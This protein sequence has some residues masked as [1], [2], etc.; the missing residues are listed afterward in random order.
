MFLAALRDKLQSLGEEYELDA[1]EVSRAIY[2][3]KPR[4]KSVSRIVLREKNNKILNHILSKTDETTGKRCKSLNLPPRRGPS[5]P[6]SKTNGSKAQTKRRRSASPSSSRK[7]MVESDRLILEAYEYFLGRLDELAPDKALKMLENFMTRIYVLVCIPSCTRIARSIVMGLGKGKNLEPVD[8]FKGMVCFNY[9]REE[10]RQDET[11]DKWN[12]LCEDVGRN[13]VERACILLAQIELHAKLPKNGEIDM[14]EDYLKV[15]MEQ[16]QPLSRH[17]A[18]GNDI[19]TFSHDGA[20]FFDEKVVPT[21]KMLKLFHDGHL[22]LLHATSSTSS[23]FSGQ[24]HHLPS[25]SFLRGATQIATSKEIEIVVLDILLNWETTEDHKRKVAFQ[26]VL[27][28]VESVALWMMVAKPKLPLRVKRCFDIINYLNDVDADPAEVSAD[29]SKTTSTEAAEPLSPIELT[30]DEKSAVLSMLNEHDFGSTAANIKVAKLI[31]ERLNEYELIESSHGRVSPVQESTLQI[32]H[33]LPQKYN[34]QSKKNGV[35]VTT[36]TGTKKS[37]S[38]DNDG[39]HESVSSPAVSSESSWIDIWDINDAEYYLHK[40]G[41]LVLLNQKVNAKISNG[42]YCKK[43][44]H[45]D[46]SPYPLT[47]RISKKYK[48]TWDINSLMNNQE[49]IINLSKQVWDL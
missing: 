19:D 22:H 20:K 3:I 30:N 32:E 7:L 6:S 4:L 33:I 1:E 12:M 26:D 25:L 48:T 9:I 23:P 38:I 21:S 24:R 35:K 40:L 15:Y 2:P 34:G 49:Y 43:R 45:F 46:T 44:I 16:R 14:M 31:L 28:H 13:T 37:N 41:N 10:A 27:R 18:I 17:D 39:Q 47:R 42:I 8:E 36:R 11:L 29:S 5:Q